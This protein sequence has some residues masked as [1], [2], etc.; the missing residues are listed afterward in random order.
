M[1]LDNLIFN[2][3]KI[4][5]VIDNNNKVLFK[6][7]NCAEILKYTNPLKA[8]RDHVRQ[9]HQISFKNINMN[10]SFILNN[11]HP[12]TIF[13]TESDFYSLISK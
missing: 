4:H 10:D 6:A 13:I 5:I 7:K 8:I 2:N 12:D 1:N 9:K 11:I 3:K